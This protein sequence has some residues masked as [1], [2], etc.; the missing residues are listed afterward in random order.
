MLCV[1]LQ[2]HRNILSAQCYIRYVGDYNSINTIQVD[3]YSS[4]L[5][6]LLL[7]N[8]EIIKKVKIITLNDFF[9][10]LS[11]S[12]DSDSSAKS[13]STV[14]CRTTMTSDG[15]SA[16]ECS[17]RLQISGADKLNESESELKVDV[18][19]FFK[20][21]FKSGSHWNLFCANC[22]VGLPLEPVYIERIQEYSESELSEG[23]FCHGN[24]LQPALQPSSRILYI[25]D[26]SFY[27]YPIPDSNINCKITTVLDEKFSSYH[28][29]KYQKDVSVQ[30]TDHSD[31]SYSD[32]S[33]INCSSKFASDRCDSEHVDQSPCLKQTGC[34]IKS[35]QNH[36]CDDYQHRVDK[37]YEYLNGSKVLNHVV[38]CQSCGNVLTSEKSS[39]PFIRFYIDKLMF[40]N[41]SFNDDHLDYTHKITLLS[42]WSLVTRSR[43]S[44]LPSKLF[45]QS[46]VR[47]E[48]L[49]LLLWIPSAPLAQFL[50]RDSLKDIPLEIY[51]KTE[52]AYK[53]LY[54]IGTSRSENVLSWRHD[55]SVDFYQ[56]SD[57]MV[58]TLARIL[59][60]SSNHLPKTSDARGFSC[61]FLSAPTHLLV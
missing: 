26:T 61:G 60:T 30:S 1:A 7:R 6:V 54:F 18:K 20:E 14:I 49:C 2:I 32:L 45:F 11:L 29:T 39:V 10:P 5:Q 58:K 59:E 43:T 51:L 21:R 38:E 27:L 46:K 36:S 13:G 15:Q 34:S 50:L 4:E 41:S 52:A 44:L 42:F 9:I 31:V 25:D 40:K 28:D 56:V 55:F 33:G 12:S 17:F 24:S 53:V 8:D 3:C 23:W 35:C 47:G 19:D 22:G 37:E 16:G 57:T 48:E